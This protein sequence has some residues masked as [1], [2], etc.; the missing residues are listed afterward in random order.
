MCGVLAC[1]AWV[2]LLVCVREW[3]AFI[4]VTVIIEVLS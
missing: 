3:H 2:G 1:V 4:I